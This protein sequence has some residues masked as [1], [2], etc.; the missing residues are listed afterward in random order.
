MRRLL[1]TV[2]AALALL[3]A[4][5]AYAQD[6][7]LARLLARTEARHRGARQNFERMLGNYP[8]FLP[9]LQMVAAR[10]GT[11]PEWLLNVM[12]CESSFNPAARNR[13]PGQTASGLM[14]IIEETASGLGTT[15]AAIRRMNPVDQLRLIEKYYWPFRGRL[16]SLADVYLAAFRGFA[17]AGGPETVIAPLNNSPKERQA[18]SLNSGLDLNGDRTITKGELEAMAFGVGRFGGGAQLTAMTRLKINKPE[19]IAGE[20]KDLIQAPSTSLYAA[21]KADTDPAVDSPTASPKTRSI[22]VH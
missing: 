18:Y 17:M 4:S 14:Q 12:A 2:I 11:R 5:P 22:Y 16:N 21:K 3:M 20:R 19:Q 10:L 15:T 1:L 7:Q 6:M 13:Q 8:G 9:E